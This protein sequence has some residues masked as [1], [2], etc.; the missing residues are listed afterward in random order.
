LRKIAHHMSRKMY[1]IPLSPKRL[2]H[3]AVH[4]KLREEIAR[5]CDQLL[6]DASP[7]RVEL[8]WRSTHSLDWEL[9]STVAAYR[10]ET[11]R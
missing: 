1:L 6:E 4:F 7:V 5:L 9:A 2:R 3:L 11:F 10:V 8:G